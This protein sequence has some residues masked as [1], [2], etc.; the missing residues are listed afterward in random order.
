MKATIENLKLVGLWPYFKYGAVVTIILCV[1]SMFV[2]D[3]P[4]G[5]V[6]MTYW[7]GMSA[8]IAQSVDSIETGPVLLS[9]SCCLMGLLITPIITV[10]QAVCFIKN[11][12][13][14]FSTNIC[15]MVIT[16]F[17]SLVWYGSLK[18]KRKSKNRGD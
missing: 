11:M 2:P 8:A 17:I 3:L 1:I 9:R 10:A 18:N 6:S 7:C 5:P 4:L 15:A 12:P 14:D 16:L 13:Y